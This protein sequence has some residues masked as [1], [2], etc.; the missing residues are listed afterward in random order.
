MLGS[1]MASL[2]K[3]I[4]AQLKADFS[5]LNQSGFLH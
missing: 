2:I 3:L 4:N 5:T 1:F